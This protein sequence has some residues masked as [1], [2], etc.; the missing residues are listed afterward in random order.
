[1]GASGFK[2]FLLA[3]LVASMGCASTETA[4]TGTASAASAPTGAAPAGAPSAPLLSEKQSIHIDAPV[5]SV[6]KVAGDYS[7]LTWVPAVKSSRA[8]R[9]NEPGS[10]RTLD[11]GGASMSETLLAYDAEGHSYTYAIDDTAANRALVPLADLVATISVTTDGKSGSIAT[12]EATFRRLDAS[13]TPAHGKD[14]VAAH[15]Q[16][17]GTISAGLNGLKSKVDAH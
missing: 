16:M 11:F 1:M 15:K 6:W 10:H 14:D 7:D 13:P 5:L 2:P 12:W 8:T 17:A 4:P 9:G 3:T